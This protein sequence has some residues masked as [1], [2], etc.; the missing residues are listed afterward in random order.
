MPRKTKK[1]RIIEKIQSIIKEWGSFSTGDVQADCSP[2]IASIGSNIVQL[3]ERF[4]LDKVSAVT[5]EH[6]REI[7][8]DEI[9]Y[10]ELTVDVLEEILE[11]AEQY[12]VEQ[13]KTWE[14]CQD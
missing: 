13:Y 1:D 12:D 14:R 10:E 9:P 7:D 5:Y 2:C 6:D 4:N 8:E 3:A 11:L